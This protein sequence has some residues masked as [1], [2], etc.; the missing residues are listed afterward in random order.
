[1]FFLLPLLG[2]MIFFQVG[3]THQLYLIIYIY[4]T[5]G[6]RSHSSYCD[7]LLT[8]ICPGKI[9][10]IWG[11]TNSWEV[12]S[13]KN[14]IFCWW[15]P[16]ENVFQ[17]RRILGKAIWNMENFRMFENLKSF[18]P[19]IAEYSGSKFQKTRCTHRHRHADTHTH[20]STPQSHSWKPFI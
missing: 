14:R 3:R 13:L 7:I 16:G 1:M 20:T 15:T 2:K 4:G 19:E 11:T 17:D 5:L 6:S 12:I 10:S 9:A 18:V 8:L